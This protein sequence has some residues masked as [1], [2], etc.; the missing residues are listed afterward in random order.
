MIESLYQSISPWVPLITLLSI[1]MAV[2]SMVFIPWLLVRMPS[3]YFI[4]DTRLLPARGT[5]AW[6]VWGLRNLLAA[7]LVT[8]GIA[9]LVLPGQGLLT[10]LIG[11]ASSTFPGKYRLE[12]ALVRRPG[13][14]RAINWVRTR[15][16][17]PPVIH[18]DDR[19]ST[20]G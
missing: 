17:K 14:Y 8:A 7:V 11:I 2:A 4:S 9:M 18:P 16:D 10:I 5:R 20:D 6:L 12:R 3:D 15:Y 19:S 13:V 1:A